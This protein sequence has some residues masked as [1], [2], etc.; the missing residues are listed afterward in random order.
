MGKFLQGWPD[1]GGL[2]VRKEGSWGMMP[3]MLFGPETATPK[4]L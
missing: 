1:T 4:V 2:T 3:D